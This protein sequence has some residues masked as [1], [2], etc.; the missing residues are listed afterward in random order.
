V[1]IT[2][3][4]PDDDD[5]Q[6]TQSW[7]DG[8]RFT[9][10]AESVKTSLERVNGSPYGGISDRSPLAHG[11]GET[12]RR[13]SLAARSRMLA[14]A[15]RG[16]DFVRGE[17]RLQRAADSLR[18]A[19]GHFDD[20]DDTAAGTA[21]ASARNDAG[22]AADDAEAKARTR[23]YL[24]LFAGEVRRLADRA[25]TLH[26][27]A[28]SPA[29]RQPGPGRGTRPWAL[30]AAIGGPPAVRG[31]GDQRPPAAPQGVRR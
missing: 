31:F 11:E 1:T 3:V 6:S 14:N 9:Y 12:T 13:A 20:A 26:D 4:C 19:A 23:D 27:R 18:A 30:G 17:A 24:E 28:V 2:A 8:K 7:D 21:L 29:A 16:S 15:I 5:L 10:S 22:A 25:A